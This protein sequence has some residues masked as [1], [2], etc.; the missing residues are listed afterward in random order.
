MFNKFLSKFFDYFFIGSSGFLIMFLPKCS[1]QPFIR[2]KLDEN[3]VQV[4]QRVIVEDA[5]E[6]EFKN[7]ELDDDL[8]LL[9]E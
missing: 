1:L 3:V 6:E 5:L 8:S 2:N 9:D 4:Y 7:L